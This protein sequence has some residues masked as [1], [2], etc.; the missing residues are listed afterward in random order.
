VFDDGEIVERGSH[1]ELL[2]ADGLYANLWRVQ[3][4]DVESLP[5]SFLDRAH[6]RMAAET[7]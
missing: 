1:E 7:S 3:V 5:D 4:G 2:A 6:E